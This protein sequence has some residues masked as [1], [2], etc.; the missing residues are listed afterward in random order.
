MREASNS[1]TKNPPLVSLRIVKR[2]Q[3]C[4]ITSDDYLN[5]WPVVVGLSRLGAHAR[6]LPNHNTDLQIRVGERMEYEYDFQIS[7]QSRPQNSP[8]FP[9]FSNSLETRLV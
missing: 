2:P 5:A 8:S 1:N 3:K 7:N 6:A 4:V 9:L